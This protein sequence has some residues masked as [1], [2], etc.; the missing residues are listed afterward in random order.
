MGL[1]A[2]FEQDAGA[3][4][5]LGG[6]MYWPLAMWLL[7]GWGA[8][9]LAVLVWGL[10]RRWKRRHGSTDSVDRCARGAAIGFVVILGALVFLNGAGSVFPLPF[11]P[12]VWRANVLR[13]RMAWDLLDGDELIGR[14]RKD[15][16]ALLG[17]PDHGQSETADQYAYNHALIDT[18]FL[19]VRY[20]EA[21]RVEGVESRST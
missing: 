1:E 14:S 4:G 19:H 18:I 15:V 13:S 9:A 16:R 10:A 5:G 21:G 6:F 11:M 7:T 20:D 12:A 2:N 8:L 17:T 3:I